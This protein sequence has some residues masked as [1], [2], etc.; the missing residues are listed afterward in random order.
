MCH[1]NFC[2]EKKI[3]IFEYYYYS[4]YTLTDIFSNHEKA[5]ILRTYALL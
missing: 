5:K 1:L 2:E 3:R 4:Y